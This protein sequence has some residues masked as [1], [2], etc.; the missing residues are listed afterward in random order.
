[1]NISPHE[2]NHAGVYQCP[3]VWVQ[4]CAHCRMNMKQAGVYPCPSVRVQDCAHTMQMITHVLQYG[5][6]TVH[7]G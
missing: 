3:S 5:F 7:N 2:V 1:M 4:D 6:K